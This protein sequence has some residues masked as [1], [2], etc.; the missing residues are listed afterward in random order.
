[1]GKNQLTKLS[2]QKPN[3]INF[4]PMVVQ[5]LPKD[6]S[7][8]LLFNGSVAS[9]GVA[10]VGWKIKEHDARL[11][12]LKIIT[13]RDV[14]FKESEDG[15]IVRLAEIGQA[16]KTALGLQQQQHDHK[17]FMVQKTLD[18]KRGIVPQPES[19]HEEVKVQINLPQHNRFTTTSA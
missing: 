5:P 17:I 14:R 18:D 11:A 10:L 6:Y 19:T 8:H 15:K 1:M 3:L 9:L 4:K 7:N 2:K 12:E 16:R 13:D